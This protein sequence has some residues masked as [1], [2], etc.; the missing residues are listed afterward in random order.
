MERKCRRDQR[1]ESCAEVRE[2]FGQSL[3][4]RNI[5]RKEREDEAAAA[6]DTAPNAALNEKFEDF[7]HFIG[8]KRLN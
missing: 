7:I 5:D 8:V 6:D 4:I 1:S 2:N 3:R